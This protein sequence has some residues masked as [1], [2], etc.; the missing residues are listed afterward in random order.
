MRAV[1]TADETD[2][3]KDAKHPGVGHDR[4]RNEQCSHKHASENLHDHHEQCLQ[5]EPRTAI[6]SQPDS[7]DK[8]RL[9][10]VSSHPHRL[11]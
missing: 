10:M 3:A 4:R 1:I 7:Y 5:L 6:L 11:W 8:A 2:K 9:Y